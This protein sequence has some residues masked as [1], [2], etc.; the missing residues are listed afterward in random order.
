MI[1]Y[2]NGGMCRDK[3]AQPHIGELYAIYVN[4]TYQGLGIGSILMKKCLKHLKDLGCTKVTLWVLETNT[5]TRKWYETKGWELEGTRK[6]EPREGFN[7]NE[8]RNEFKLN[9]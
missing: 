8:I 7:L 9:H 1:G 4:P 3:D 2:C 5:K 6:S